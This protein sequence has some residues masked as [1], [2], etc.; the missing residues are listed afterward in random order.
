MGFR[1]LERVRSVWGRIQFNLPSRQSRFK[2]AAM[3]I[4]YPIPFAAFARFE[5]LTSEKPLLH[6][7]LGGGP[8]IAKQSNR[9]DIEKAYCLAANRVVSVLDG[10]QYLVQIVAKER[11]K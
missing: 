4:D 10:R 6:C 2:Q 1:W 8:T 9:S 5:R 7:E 11:Y 3:T